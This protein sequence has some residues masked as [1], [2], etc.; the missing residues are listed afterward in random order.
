MVGSSTVGQGCV[1]G[2]EALRHNL[3]LTLW[4]PAEEKGTCHNAQPSFP[5]IIP[6]RPRHSTLVPNSAGTPSV[7]C[8]PHRAPAGVAVY[9][10]LAGAAG[11]GRRH[12]RLA[13]AT[14][15]AAAALNQRRQGAPPVTR[16]LVVVA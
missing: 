7:S 10:F 12:R 16:Y 6:L 8:A 4:Q 11:L 9:P 5:P 1:C 2:W 15:A 14:Q 3:V 13:R